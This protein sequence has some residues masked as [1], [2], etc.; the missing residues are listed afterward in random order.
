MT[1]RTLLRAGLQALAGAAALTFA[2]PVLAVYPERPITLVVPFAAGGPTD[3]ISRLMAE[4][5]SRALGQQVIV[6]NVVGGGGTV[7]GYPR[8]QGAARRLHAAHG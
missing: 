2:T 1:S 6:E 8:R 7:G 5:M 4:P 3:I